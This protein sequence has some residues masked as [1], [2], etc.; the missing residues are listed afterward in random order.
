MFETN[1]PVFCF[2]YAIGRIMDMTKRLIGIDYLKFIATFMIIVFHCGMF[3]NNTPVMMAVGIFFTCSGYLFKEKNNGIFWKHIL[4]LT[5]TTLVYTFAYMLLNGYVHHDYG[6]TSMLNGLNLIDLLVF[7]ENAIYAHLWFMGSYIYTLIIAQYG[8]NHIPSRIQTITMISLWIISTTWPLV[9]PSIPLCY[10]RNF[11]LMGLPCFLLGQW[12]KINQDRLVQFDPYWMV[13]IAAV[14]SIINLMVL[15]DHID[16]FALVYSEPL[17]LVSLMILAIRLSVSLKDDRFIQQYSQT[18]L[19][20]YLI[21]PLVYQIINALIIRFVDPV[22]F[23]LALIRTIFTIV[24]SML[25]AIAIRDAS[26]RFI[27]KQRSKQH[28]H[29]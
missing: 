25:F 9:V 12:I 8:L 29:F 2:G 13:G 18:A 26:N 16:A 19:H 24:I 3:D 15:P 22:P 11:L 23:S 27:S 20:I 10:T 14:L 7:N 21:H 17:L 5:M 28:K 6:L 1:I 4:G